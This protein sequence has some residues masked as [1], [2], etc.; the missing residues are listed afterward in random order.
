[1]NIKKALKVKNKLKGKIADLQ[2]KLYKY[3]I[4]E[5]GQKADYDTRLVLNELNETIIE[6]VDLKTKI[7]KANVPVVDRI[8]R[9]SELKGLAKKVKYINCDKEKVTRGTIV[10]NTYANITAIEKEELIMKIE[11]EIDQ[12]QDQLDDFNHNTNI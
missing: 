10:T 3:N 4:V 9:L 7:Q 8:F 2:T 11:N 1:M 12:I 5:E 6:F